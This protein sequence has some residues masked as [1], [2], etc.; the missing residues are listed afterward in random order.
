AGSNTVATLL[1]GTMLFLGKTKHAPAR[2]FIDAGVPVGLATDF[3]PGTSPT[4]SLPLVL[5]LG[6]SQLHLS[7]A[8]AVVAATVNGAAALAL[9]EEVGQL[10]PGFR[11]DLA[12]FDIRDVR[13]LPYWYGDNR[14]TATFVGG[15]PCHSSDLEVT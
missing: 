1:P 11:A 14:C 4:P 13:E 10:A 8:E 3:N 6:V 5:T 12:V 7:A 9:A 2:R 15:K